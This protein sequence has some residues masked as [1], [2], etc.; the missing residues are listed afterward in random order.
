MGFLRQPC[1]EA[2]QS[3]RWRIGGQEL[4][5]EELA[6]LPTLIEWVGGGSFE[7][8]VIARAGGLGAGA[9]RCA[10]R[11]GLGGGAQHGEADVGRSRDGEA[12]EAAAG[13]A[14]AGCRRLRG[15]RSRLLPEIPGDNR[16]DRRV[17]PPAG[18]RRSSSCGSAPRGHCTPRR[19]VPLRRCIRRGRQVLRGRGSASLQRNVASHE[20]EHPSCNATSRRIEL[21]PAR[22]LHDQHIES[23]IDHQSAKADL[24]ASAASL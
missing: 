4:E 20:R 8:E 13:D 23:Q 22:K 6:Q 7:P 3:L 14:G 11:G 5:E 15:E 1:G 24:S 2:F 12:C 10:L 9:H 19:G 21:G 16:R 18:W 17:G